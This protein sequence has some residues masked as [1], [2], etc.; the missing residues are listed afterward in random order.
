MRDRVLLRRG[1]GR[2]PALGRSAQVVP[3]GCGAGTPRVVA[4]CRLGR[5]SRSADRR[6]LCCRATRTR[7]TTS[8]R[9]TRKAAASGWA[10]TCVP[11]PASPPRQRA[12]HAVSLFAQVSTW[13]ECWEKAVYWFTL[14][15]EQGDA[16]AQCNLATC[17]LKGQGV[18]QNRPEA[19]RWY[20]QAAQRCAHDVGRWWRSQR[21]LKR[22][23]RGAGAMRRRAGTWRHCSVDGPSPSQAVATTGGG[24]DLRGLPGSE[25]E[26]APHRG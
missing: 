13:D 26:E 5:G 18:E 1:A 10:L 11:V 14:A 8:G 19:I 17:Y 9:V 12:S 15:A 7:S 6:L 23:V 2:A 16:A 20:E 24:H 25:A 22:V 4:G 21:C 3:S